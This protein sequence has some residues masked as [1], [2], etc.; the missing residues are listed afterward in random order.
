[1]IRHPRQWRDGY[2]F[3]SC[4]I[5]RFACLATVITI[6]FLSE[7]S[8]NAQNRA[9]DEVFERAEQ[10]EETG[11]DTHFGPSC[12]DRVFYPFRCFDAKM[13]AVGGPTFLGLYAPMWQG[14]T[15]GSRNDQMMSQSLNL[16]GEW[17]LLHEPGHEGTLYTFFL[18]ESESLGTTAAQFADAAGTT[19]LPN[20]D[21]GDAV[22]AL[23]HVAW[24]QKMFDGRLEVSAGQLALKIFIDQNDYAGWDRVS[25]ASGPLSGNQVRNFPIAALGVDTTAHLTDDFQM[26]MVVADADGYPFY[27]D[28]NSFGRRFVYIPGFVYTPEICGLGKGRYEVNFSHIERTERFGGAGSSSS[29]WLFSFQQELSPKLATFFRFGTGDGRRTAVQQSLAT[30]LVFTQFLGYNNDWL[31]VGFMWQD[32]S[33][34]TRRDDYGMEMFWRLQ[35]TE[36]IQLTPDVQ[37]YFDPSRNPN[38]DL[39]AAFGL[40][41]GIY[42]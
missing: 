36:N 37:L 20:D 23:A 3:V 30:G 15:Q 11:V 31:G 5:P 7:D 21:V 13:E 10:L 2:F 33:D 18:H 12:I 40:R 6:T 24:T 34:S 17:E 1:M 25:F 38:R 19:I 4:W 28:F 29:V 35:L 26:S 32:P 14:G 16:Y 39:E 9:P 22:N 27:P 8:A 42:F 41:I